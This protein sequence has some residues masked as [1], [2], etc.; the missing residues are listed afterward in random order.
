MNGPAKGALVRRGYA[1]W[2]ND[3]EQKR[4]L[5]TYFEVVDYFISFFTNG[6]GIAQ[7]KAKLTSFKQL[8]K[9]RRKLLR[10]DIEKCTTPRS[11]I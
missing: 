3:R 4:K 6:D 11:C 9:C 7:L 1:T 8:E 5:K 2:E 10:S